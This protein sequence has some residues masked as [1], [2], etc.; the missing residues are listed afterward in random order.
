MEIVRLRVPGHRSDNRE[1][2]TAEQAAMMSW[3]DELVAAGRAKTLMAGDIRSRCAAVHE[4]LGRPD[5][6]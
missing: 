5:A 6:W 4:V 3:K 1:C 2:P